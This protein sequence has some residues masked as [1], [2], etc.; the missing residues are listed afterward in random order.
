M[1][2]ITTLFFI[3]LLTGFVSCKKKNEEIPPSSVPVLEFQKLE[4]KSALPL[5]P[6]DSVSIYLTYADGDS[7]IGDDQKNNAFPKP[8][9][10]AELFYKKNGVF[11]HWKEPLTNYNYFN[12]HLPAII[13]PTKNQIIENGPYII[14][15]KSKYRG[16]IIWKTLLLVPPSD[17]IGYIQPGDTLRF[18]IQIFDRAQHYSNK[19]TTSEFVFYKR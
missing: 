9:F 5:L 13:N 1:S 17:Y 16:E 19:V 8:N 11:V 15:V 2:K 7:D 10:L 3:L 12:G 18:E 14:T 6:G 4:T